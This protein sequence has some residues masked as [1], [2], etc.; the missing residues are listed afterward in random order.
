MYTKYSLAFLFSL[1]FTIGISQ[2]LLIDENFDLC[3]LPDGWQLT[4]TNDQDAGVTFGYM[5]NPKSDS[6][7][8]DGTCMV[9]FDDDILGGNQPS[10]KAELLTPSVNISG[11]SSVELYMDLAFRDYSTSS[12]EVFVVA[13]G[14]YFSISK[15]DEGDKTG[16]QMSQ[17][18][19]YVADLSFVTDADEI[20]VAIVYD[21]DGMYAWWAGIDN[22]RIVGEDKGEIIIKEDFDD[23]SLPDQWE[24]E[25][26]KGA[27]NWQ[28]GTVSNDKTSSTS[29]NG[30]CFA[31]FDD[32]G[33][34]EDA[35]FSTAE[36]RTPV[37]D[38]SEFAEYEVNFDLIFRKAGDFENISVYVFNGEEYFLMNEYINAVGGPGFSS[39]EKIAIDIT[40]Y[41]SPTMQVVFRYEDGDVYGWWTGIDN[42]KI[43]GKGDIN[44]ICSKATEL[45]IGDDC[46]T[47]SNANAVFSGPGASCFENLNH[48]LWYSISAD[49]SGI[50][51]LENISEF[52]DIINIYSGNCTDLVEVACI[53]KDEHG[54]EGEK[55]F[56]ELSQNEDILIRVAGITSRYGSES[57]VSCLSANWVEQVPENPNFD[58]LAEAIAISPGDDCLPIVT[59]A[60]NTEDIL[61][62]TNELARSDIWL[63]FNCETDG[64]YKVLTDG[65]FS[66]SLTIFEVKDSELVEVASNNYGTAV[67]LE[68]AETGKSYAIQV[69]GLFA[70]I[71]GSTCVKI[72]AVTSNGPENNTCQ[73]AAPL[74]INGELSITNEHN[75]FSMIYPSCNIYSG[76][77]SW[78]T[79]NSGDNL[80]L[81]L[82][83]KSE[84][85]HA[86]SVY[87]GECSELAEIWCSS[88]QDP[89]S[90]YLTINGLQPNLDY[91]IQIASDYTSKDKLVGLIDIVLK[92][93]VEDEA[94]PLGLS[95][96]AICQ[97]GSTAILDVNPFGG[98]GDYTL[99]GHQHG[100]VLTSGETYLTIVTDEN[101]CEVSKKGIIDC[102]PS[103]CMLA[104][105]SDVNNLNCH[106]AGDGTISIQIQNANEPVTY[107]WSEDGVEGS[108][109][110][111]LAAGQ[112]RVT[113]V[114]ADQCV[115]V[116]EVVLVQPDALEI[117][118][119]TADE[120][121][122]NLKDGSATVSISG[123]TFPYAISWSGGGTSSAIN[124]LSPGDYEVMITDSKGCIN[125]RSF[126]V[127][128]YNCVF[129]LS[130]DFVTPFCSDS[131]DGAITITNSNN[132]ITTIEWSNGM[133]GTTIS[134]LTQGM[135]T[136]II[137]LADGC[138]RTETYS[139]DGP[140][141][142]ALNIVSTID[143]L[144]HG[145]S[146]GVIELT[147]DGGTGAISFTWPDG[148][149]S[150]RR[151][152]LPAGEY[153]VITKDANDCTSAVLVTVVQPNEL[154]IASSM[155]TDT[156][157]SDSQD[158]LICVF[159]DGGVAPYD[160]DWGDAFPAMSKLENLASGIYSLTVYDLNGCTI[161]TTMAV[162]SPEAIN[163]IVT[164]IK[165]DEGSAS[166]GAVSIEVSGGTT[167]YT[168]EWILEG[169]TVS[170]D[171]DPD[172]LVNGS[173]T[174][175]ITDAN[176]CILQDG[177][178]LESTGIE[179]LTEIRMEVF[180][181]PSTDFIVLSV[182][183]PI[184]RGHKVTLIGV[185]GQVLRVV[186]LV[187][188]KHRFSLE[189]YPSGMY[190]IEVSEGE[191]K[192]SMPFVK[193]E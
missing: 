92:D 179:R 140:P 73:E 107:N 130:S 145:E 141:E 17:S 186:D 35:P 116:L 174:L 124:D 125:V 69:A 120:T 91:F 180:P 98:T 153:Q 19:S 148:I 50:L 80:V 133:M 100:T 104:I 66:E 97:E 135:Y 58:V 9:I 121:G 87:S 189:D 63:L 77:D 169:E 1:I 57:G 168:Y 110:E 172:G 61:P 22:L 65:D 27:D 41:R 117:L 42:V 146:T 64:T 59:T 163:F 18:I 187:N 128:P 79:F 160:F 183:G 122:Q 111:G 15:Y 38:G 151:E 123:G 32:D 54:F 83:T 131:E 154:D 184:P 103:S 101:G 137:T 6:L 132:D 170:T 24:I 67:E 21:D 49:R 62:I 185:S 89:C 71:E 129:E 147:A 12:L 23:C 2:D 175:I 143:P 34:G 167:P 115:Q 68:K 20:Q 113:V 112:Y 105:S 118:L 159:V 149:L 39:F 7:T 11:Y 152:D 26:L 56:L 33:I 182:T 74:D 81:Y 190:M 52:N 166:I 16:N 43:Y 51:Q 72:E 157:C 144:C 134:S 40:K 119:T 82:K 106:E 161:D 8:I 47:V 84:F 28:F 142:I 55:V 156:K 181:N 75:T 102:E 31:Y 29:M 95:V 3:A 114:D 165:L 108:Q 192:V 25:I 4:V 191:E 188:E 5:T 48:S 127:S 78:V 126:T 136:A 60:A 70:T 10:F 171:E 45:I 96:N 164:D 85:A 158:G 155:A 53:N 150:S 37:F 36:I 93:N 138:T 162:S 94:A 76:S 44:D 46:T 30:S 193:V 90:S 176:G 13:D 99:I 14:Q 139:L 177:I 173:Y 88:S 178:L 86:I 109:P